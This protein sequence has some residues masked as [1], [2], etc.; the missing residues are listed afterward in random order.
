MLV[1]CASVAVKRLEKPST[2]ESQ[3]KATPSVTFFD[4][5][6]GREL[7]INDVLEHTERARVILFG[8]LH[9]HP[10][11]L[12]VTSAIWADRLRLQTV[13]RK[14]ALL[15]EFFERDHQLAIDDYLAGITDEEAF[16]TATGRR[17]TNYPD[18]HREMFEATKAAG[19]AVIA[20]NA[21]RRYVRLARTEGYDH[22][23]AFSPTQRATFVLPRDEQGPPDY[24]DRFV[25]AM[26]GMDA[27]H[28]GSGPLDFLRSQLVWDATMA[29]SV[30][31]ALKAGHEPIALVVGRFHVEFNGATRQFLRHQRP[32]ARVLSIVMVPTWSDTLAEEDKG[33]GDI[34]VYVGPVVRSHAE[35][36]E[37]S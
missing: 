32:S 18:A 28:G 1:G 27:S 12:P 5:H 13:G 11:G 16:K 31:R 2:V 20:A 25:Q 36:D 19:G 4:G 9:D 14:P 7:S 37:Q 17:S 22:L 10:V 15:L 33:R 30:A 35:D 3:L 26:G 6:E 29:D 24:R 21:P 8:E 34:V 23:R